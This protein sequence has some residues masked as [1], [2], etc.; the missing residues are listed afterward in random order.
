MSMASVAPS[1]FFLSHPCAYLHLTCPSS[2]LPLATGLTKACF[3]PSRYLLGQCLGAVL[4]PSYSETFGRKPLYTLSSI[5][6]CIFCVMIAD[7]PNF[8][9]VV[10]GRFI[11][12]VLSSVPTVIIAGSIED[13][14]DTEDRIWMVFLWA[15]I[16]NLG[17]VLGP[18]TSTYIT[19]S[20][21]WLG[22]FPVTTQIVSLV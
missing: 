13:M 4:F 12:G 22:L 9:A 14:F 10:I 3:L 21:G 16:A 20:F 5:L 11:T 19:Y 7:V 8:A 6:Y 18:I 15:V 1:P 17:L 2:Y